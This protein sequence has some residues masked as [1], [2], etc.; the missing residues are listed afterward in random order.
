MFHF[1]RRK[2]SVA[3]AVVL[4]TLWS[5]FG[6]WVPTS[7]IAACKQQENRRDNRPLMAVPEEGSVLH[8]EGGQVV[9]HEATLEESA[10]LGRRDTAMKLEEIRTKSPRRSARAGGL[11]VI[12]RASKQLDDFPQAKQA[13]LRV[14]TTWESLIE[15]PITVIVDV[16]FGPTRFGNP[17]AAGDIG[18]TGFQNIA[19]ETPYPGVRKQLIANASSPAEKTICES[20]PVA[21]VPTELGDTVNVFGPATLFRALGILSA[22][23]DP[24]QELELPPPPSIGFNSA[25]NF[26]FDSGNGIDADK[27]DFEGLAL[28]EMG[29]VLGFYSA[30]GNK[31]IYSFAPV[32]VSVWDLFRFRPGITVDSFSSARRALRSGGVHL[33]FAGGAELQLSTGREDRTRGDRQQPHHWKDNAITGLYI[34]IMDPTFGFGEH[35]VITRNDL[36]A[37]EAMGY[38]VAHNIE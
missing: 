29:H 3:L 5:V 22:V 20:L 30:A 23:A 26:D 4:T 15:T 27:I 8:M 25:F 21:T 36:A 6:V 34:G 19:N 38:Q 37:L 28:H 24:E 11:H 32:F 9:C 14:V 17:Y 33:F 7:T 13:F 31:E 35:T 12:L 16:D 2:P 18:A 10:T 1:M